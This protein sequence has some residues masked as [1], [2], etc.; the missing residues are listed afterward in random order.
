[1]FAEKLREN[2]QNVYQT[3][4]NLRADTEI[5]RILSNCEIESNKGLFQYKAFGIQPDIQELVVNGL[6]GEGLDTKIVKF[7]CPCGSGMS[8][9]CVCS[10]EEIE[11]CEDTHIL[12]SWK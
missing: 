3:K 9:G 4:N 6:K 2:A 11:Q 5:K 8:Y 10:D 1:M 7:R 12:I